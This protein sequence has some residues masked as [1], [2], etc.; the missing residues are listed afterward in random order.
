M[1]FYS[2]KHL[3]LEKKLKAGKEVIYQLPLTQ[4]TLLQTRELLTAPFDNYCCKQ[5]E[6]T[7]YTV[8]TYDF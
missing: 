6:N 1:P 2:G 7:S 4:M 5:I 8:F 3:V